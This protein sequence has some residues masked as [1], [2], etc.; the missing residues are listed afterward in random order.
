MSELSDVSER[1]SKT[2]TSKSRFPHS[3]T[4]RIRTALLLKKTQKKNTIGI[5]KKVLNE[6]KRE[7]TCEAV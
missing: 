3:R 6:V 5:S 4:D 7:D 1:T 2:K